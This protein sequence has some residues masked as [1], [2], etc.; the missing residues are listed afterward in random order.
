MWSSSASHRHTRQAAP[1][2][3]RLL[4]VAGRSSRFAIATSLRGRC[5]ERVLVALGRAERFCQTALPGPGIRSQAASARW[6]EGSGAQGCAASRLRVSVRACGGVRV[7][8]RR[9]WRRRV[10][11]RADDAPIFAQHSACHALHRMPAPE[12]KWLRRSLA[13]SSTSRP[14]LWEVV[15][16]VLCSGG[17]TH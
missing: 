10:G 17:T 13:S 7:R 11:P 14:R 1:V 9:L 3:A 4:S 2:G 6:K 16:D 15:G 8:H 12:A 5:A